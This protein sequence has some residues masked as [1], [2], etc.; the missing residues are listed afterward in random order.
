MAL[1]IR[2]FGRTPGPPRWLGWIFL[3]LGLGLLAG[4]GVAVWLELAFRQRSVETEGRI[5]QMIRGSS[6][7]SRG[8]STANWTPV[9]AFRLP[10]GREMRVTADFSSSPPCC[11]VGDAVQV[12]YD[13]ADPS[14]A[15]MAGF[16]SSWLV[17]TILG[18]IGA[19]FA[20]IGGVVMRFA[21]RG[22][23]LAVL[24]AQGAVPNMMTFEVPLVG[25]RRQPGGAHILQARWT[26]PRSGVQR[27]FESVPI[28]FDPVPQMRRM[29]RVA[30]TFDPGD[31]A[32][33]Y[34]MDLSFLRDPGQAPA[35]PVRRG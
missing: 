21:L 11:K 22:G 12:R 25:L 16:L 24:P 8:H 7:D 4:A 18:G 6:T 2:G 33:P 27:M 32:S 14:R 5:V 29:D 26:D 10:D 20:L 34:A 28:P 35:G 15:Q 31:P 19:V 3:L 23:T 9:F 13:P 17:A 1:T 30:V